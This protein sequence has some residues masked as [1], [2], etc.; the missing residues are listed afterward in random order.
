MADEKNEPSGFKVVDR[1]SFTS[2]GSRREEGPSE[3]K[4]AEPPPP[5]ENARRARKRSNPQRQ[6]FPTSRPVLKPW[7]PISAPPPCFSLA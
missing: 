3:V 4:K 5:A 2:E 1:R 6:N 7:S